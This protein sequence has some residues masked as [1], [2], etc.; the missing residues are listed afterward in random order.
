MAV[1]AYCTSFRY[2]GLKKYKGIKSISKVGSDF[3]LDTETNQRTERCGESFQSQ[4]FDVP[5]YVIF[6]IRNINLYG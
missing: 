6:K 3:I 1:A 4:L 2:F 5:T